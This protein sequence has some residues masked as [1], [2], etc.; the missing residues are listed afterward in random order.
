[1]V[2]LFLVRLMPR[3]DLPFCDCR[4]LERAAHDPDNPIQFDP[5]LNEYNLKTS[6]GHSLRIYHC[7]FC[8][9]RAPE[10]LRAQMF[11]TVSSEESERLHRLVQEIQSK[12]DAIRVLGTPTDVLEPGGRCIEPERDGRPS[13]IHLYKTLRYESVSDTAVLD[14]H[15]DQYG[16]ATTSL[17]GKY[18]GKPPRA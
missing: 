17:C 11:A 9:G 3:A 1:V 6:S 18:L 7:P 4:W 14:V 10:S 2:Y 13:Y 12:A 16:R 5:E 8:A 15:I